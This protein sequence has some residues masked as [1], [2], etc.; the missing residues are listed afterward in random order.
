MW[1]MFDC[2]EGRLGY[3]VRKSFA[4]IFKIMAELVTRLYRMRFQA[5]CALS[6][7]VVELVTLEYS[8]LKPC[9]LSRELEVAQYVFQDIC[10]LL[11]RAS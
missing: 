10:L 1:V 7:K 5:V 11:D 8:A 9:P 3:W 4:S 6:K 2:L